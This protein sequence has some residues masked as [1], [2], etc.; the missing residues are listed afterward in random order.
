MCSSDLNSL[1]TL[2]SITVLKYLAI[3]VI[4]MSFLANY[5]LAAAVIIGVT[6]PV[7]FSL[8]EVAT[9]LSQYVESKTIAIEQANFHKFMHRYQSVQILTSLCNDGNMGR[10]VFPGHLFCFSLMFLMVINFGS[11]GQSLG[12]SLHP[13][14]PLRGVCVQYLHIHH[15]AGHFPQI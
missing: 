4:Q 3:L 12:Q 5:A 13:D 6:Y 1:L 8:Y 14:V 2:T 15:T 7:F 11:Q 9:D 10:I